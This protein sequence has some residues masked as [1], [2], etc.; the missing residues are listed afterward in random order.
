[1]PVIDSVHLRA[2]KQFFSNTVTMLSDHCARNLQTRSFTSLCTRHDMS[3][4]TPAESWP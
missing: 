4:L 3:D 1:M 2:G